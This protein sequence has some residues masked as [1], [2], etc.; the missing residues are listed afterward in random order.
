MQPQ[1][2]QWDLVQ[3][4][5]WEVFIQPRAVVVVEPQ[6]IRTITPGHLG[7]LAAVEQHTLETT[8]ET[9]AQQSAQL[10]DLL[11]ETLTF[12]SLWEPAAVERVRQATLV[13]LRLAA[14]EN[15]IQ[16]PELQHFMPAAAGAE[17][18]PL[19]KMADQAAAGRVV[20]LELPDLQILAVERADRVQM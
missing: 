10:R 2:L 20:P 18:Q 9:A 13:Q 4:Q 8:L 3:A 1:N 11:A 19:G 12:H 17:L 7:H 6:M 15:Q 14:L 5:L 16:S